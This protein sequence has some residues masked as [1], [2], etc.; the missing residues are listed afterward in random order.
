MSEI[1]V[2]PADLAAEQA[3][4]NALADSI[5][6]TV[7]S[8]NAAAGEVSP[9]TT[10]WKAE[11]EALDSYTPVAEKLTEGMRAIAGSLT[12]IGVTMRAQV[13]LTTHRVTVTDIIE[14]EGAGDVHSIDT[15]GIAPTNGYSI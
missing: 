5:A 9:S 1:E 4:L 8:V 3:R 12:T 15:E 11:W 10:A 13:N 14:G 6:E 7:S 2:D